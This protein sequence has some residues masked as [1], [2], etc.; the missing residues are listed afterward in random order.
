MNDQHIFAIFFPDISL[1]QENLHVQI[2]DKEFLH[3]ITRVLRLERDSPL[4]I[5]DEANKADVIIQEVDVRS[6][7][8]IVQKLE[9]I[10][11]L[12]PCIT[13][14]LGLLKK[15]S[16]EEVLYNATELG[17]NEI[18]PV[19]TQKIHR[20]WWSDKMYD[21]FKKIIIAATEQAKNFSLP[22]LHR[23][24]SLNNFVEQYA[25]WN[26]IRLL[27]EPDGESLQKKINSICEAEK[28]LLFIGPEGDIT[29]P[30]REMLLQANFSL[31]RL[32]PTI[33]RSVQAV[34]IAVGILRSII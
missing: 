12:K 8:I 5:F 19:I 31:I 20:M 33:L 2:T 32:T 1:W 18:Q 21:R 25:S 9:R 34:N 30:E 26:G 11:P 28:I 15:E 10:F 7:S 24:I 14:A 29:L 4:I 27:A 17:V 22:I 23:P 13:V 3:R 16:F 6:C